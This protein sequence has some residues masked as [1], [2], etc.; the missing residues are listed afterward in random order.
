MRV[1]WLQ[2]HGIMQMLQQESF[3]FLS[4]QELAFF[5]PGADKGNACSNPCEEY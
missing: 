1:G 2:V 4:V 3:A 5:K